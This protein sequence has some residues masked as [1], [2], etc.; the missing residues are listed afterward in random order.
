MNSNSMP[1]HRE[2][3]NTDFLTDFPDRFHASEIADR[4]PQQKDI[5][6][7]MAYGAMAN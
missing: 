6:V 5:V 7:Y 4:D 1:E 2:T 3:E